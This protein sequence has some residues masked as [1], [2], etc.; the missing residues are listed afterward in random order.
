MNYDAFK[1]LFEKY[2]PISSMA[3]D[4]VAEE[5][6]VGAVKDFPDFQLVL[7]RLDSEVFWLAIFD[8]DNP[9]INIVDGVAV[10][11]KKGAVATLLVSPSSDHHKD[12]KGNRLEIRSHSFEGVAWEGMRAYTDDPKTLRLSRLFNRL[13]SEVLGLA[14]KGAEELGSS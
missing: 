13:Y 9:K 1:K 2:V 4:G 10:P 6:M 3:Y 14:E 5:I 12:R 11:A 8:D 7:G